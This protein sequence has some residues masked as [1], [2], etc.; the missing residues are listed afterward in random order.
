[1][2]ASRV[3][4]LSVSLTLQISARAKELAAEGKDVIDLSCGEPD[5]PSP[6]HVKEAGIA[7]INENFTRYTAAAGI[8]PLR[9]AVREKLARENG[10]EYDVG[11]IVISCG[12]KHALANALMALVDPGDEV[13]VPT[14]C[15]LSYPE[16]VLLVGGKPVYAETTVE[17]RFHLTPDILRKALS[18]KTKL[19]ILNSPTNPTG[20]ALDRQE[21]TAL[22]AVLKDHQA[23][24]LSDE[25]YEHIRF[26]G[27]PHFSP[28]QLPE[29]KDRTVLINGVSK[30]YS[31]TGW[32]IGYS[33]APKEIS[34]GMLKVQSQMTSSACSVS[35]RA[36]LAGLRG[37]QSVS[38]EMT[39]DFA[40][41]R[42]LCCELLNKCGGMKVA[43]PEGTFYIFPDIS[44]YYGKKAN[45]R[46]LK[47]SFDVA[48]YLI[49][50]ALVATVP[51]GAFKAPNCLRISYANSDENVKRGVGRICEKLQQLTD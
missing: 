23:I 3:K 15:W 42:T 22:C 11:Q 24:I 30:C 47:D 49:E 29:M 50:E 2:L 35:Q 32:R 38:R 37:D 44:F 7:A 39:K 18:P 46:M 33:A 20:A 25:I 17:D 34:Q 16:L 4:Q 21:I 51:G 48:K 40:R 31:M 5:H 28:A 8:P 1:M 26:D 13:I 12:A 6:I 43:E 19:L 10:L 41:R 9:E 36:A 14:P 27:K 45:G